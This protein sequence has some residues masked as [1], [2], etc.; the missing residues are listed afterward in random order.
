MKKIIYVYIFL[1]LFAAS[2]FSVFMN[3]TPSIAWTNGSARNAYAA[4]VNPNN[5]LQ[6]YIRDYSLDHNAY[7]YYYES[8]GTK[9]Y[10]HPH[11]YY[12]THDWIS[13]SAWELLIKYEEPNAGMTNNILQKMSSNYADIK[14][15]YLLGTEIPDLV[16]RYSTDFTIKTSCGN[17]VTRSSF[18]G[19]LGGM[20]HQIRCTEWGMPTVDNLHR[21]AERMLQK[22]SVAFQ[23]H[24]DL[25]EGFLFLGA[26]T[27]Y[28]ADATAPWHLIDDFDDQSTTIRNCI[29]KL[30][31]KKYPDR[32]STDFF[33]DYDV[34]VWCQFNTIES[35][36]PW[37]SVYYA[38]Q[39]AQYGHD[40]WRGYEYT[41]TSYG[42]DFLLQYNP[43]GDDRQFWNLLEGYTRI[44]FWE[45][46]GW[47][48]LS[49]DAFHYFDTYLYLLNTAIYYCAA[50]VKDASS[51]APAYGESC[52]EKQ[53]NDNTIDVLNTVSVPNPILNSVLLLVTIP[54]FIAVIN[55][56]IWLSV[57]NKVD[58]KETVQVSLDSWWK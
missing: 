20:N 47:D 38:Q 32:K 4:K 7:S 34:D 35:R 19:V 3:A 5:P 49:G 22:A 58:Q 1:F 55:A 48:S 33:D 39:D 50:A 26:M 15:Y 37:Y 42:P 21:F 46:N 12:G 24:K 53:Q 43:S 54:G 23:E 2:V 9:V 11:N 16:C 28:I 18:S 51:L 57:V 52:Q 17:K 14:Y 30:T 27:H 8:D 10:T 13:E 29:G 6:E 56:M 36:D 31:F 45:L 25:Q 44:I 41:Y 40:R